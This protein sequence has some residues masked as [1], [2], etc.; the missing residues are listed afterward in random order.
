MLNVKASN[1]VISKFSILSDSLQEGIFPIL[2]DKLL[3]GLSSFENG[4]NC[5][6]KLKRLTAALRL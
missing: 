1:Y 6:G 5:N 3:L 2:A 4:H